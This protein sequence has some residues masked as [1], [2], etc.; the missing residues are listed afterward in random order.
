MSSGICLG[1]GVGL[2]LGLGLG[3]GLGLRLGL[4]LGLGL[5]SGLGVG[6]GIGVPVGVRRHMR[7]LHV[8]RCFTIRIVVP[9]SWFV[10][11]QAKGRVGV[12]L[13]CIRL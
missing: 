3:L 6:V 10:A 5:G 13:R 9:L 7:T 8:Q 12:K 2:K 4:G 11:I 1:L